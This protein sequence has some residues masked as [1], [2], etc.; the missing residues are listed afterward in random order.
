MPDGGKLTVQ[1]VPGDQYVFL[2][3]ED[4]GEGM[5]EETIKQIFIPFFTTKDVGQGTGLG[6]AVVHGIIASHGGSIN[7]ESTLGSGT[8]FE[9]KLPV[10]NSNEIEKRSKLGSFN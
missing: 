6:L 5:S 3:V 8:C 4:T 9:I 10:I 7:V 2:I 1:T